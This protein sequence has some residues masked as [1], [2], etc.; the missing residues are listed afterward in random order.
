[1]TIEERLRLAKIY[2]RNIKIG[3]KVSLNPPQELIQPGNSFI[4]WNKVGV[5]TNA[6]DHENGHFCYV[7]FETI[8]Y[9]LPFYT[10]DLKLVSPFT[11]IDYETV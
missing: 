11:D 8:P 9:K 3:S 2:D 5:V 10:H 1:M 4:L 7:Q 6:V